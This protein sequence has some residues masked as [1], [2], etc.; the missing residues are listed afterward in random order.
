MRLKLSG[1][2]IDAPQENDWIPTHSLFSMLLNRLGDSETKRAHDEAKT[3][4]LFTFNMINIDRQTNQ[5][6]FQFS[7]T[8]ELGERLL[9]SFRSHNLFRVDKYIMEVSNITKLPGLAIKERYVFQGRVLA[10]T[11]DRQALHTIEDIEACLLANAKTK[12]KALGFD[13]PDLTIT[14][15]KHE[16]AITRYKKEK[17]S[18]KGDVIQKTVRIPSHFVTIE[19]SGNLFAIE[20][21]YN[22]GFGQNT[23]SGNG[24]MREVV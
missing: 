8:D 3:P 6:H 18:L 10:S 16:K 4:C 11:T 24:L 20:A 17:V 23:G 21:L 1:R 15:L 22:I 7:S 2:L 5:F 13:N 9:K 19:V 14:I 12:L